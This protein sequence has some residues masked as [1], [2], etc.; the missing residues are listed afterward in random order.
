MSELA[1]GVGFGQ[2][3]EAII[4][5]RQDPMRT[6]DLGVDKGCGR[7]SPRRGKRIRK[8]MQGLGVECDK[9]HAC[10]VISALR[11]I[12][13]GDGSAKARIESLGLLSGLNDVEIDG[14]AGCN[15][16]PSCPI[17][18]GVIA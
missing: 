8:S 6:I 12:A 5:R 10:V 2:R 4:G 16:H 1:V 15:S 3:G 17:A 13:L 14:I 18:G 7:H 9:R 11:L